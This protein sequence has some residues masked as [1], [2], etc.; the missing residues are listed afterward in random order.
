MRVRAAVI[1]A[2]LAFALVFAFARPGVHAQNHDG[3]VSPELPEQVEWWIDSDLLEVPLVRPPR[4]ATRV[5]LR[6]ATSEER[7][8][9]ASAGKWGPND[10]DGLLLLDLNRDG[11]EDAF[12]CVGTNGFSGYCFVGS[13]HDEG[14]E[15][16]KTDVDYPLGLSGAHTAA[17]DLGTGRYLMVAGLAQ[18]SPGKHKNLVQIVRYDGTTFVTETAYEDR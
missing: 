9:L 11:S 4:G 13:R 5:E 16:T 15:F 14:W 2:T 18:P 3:V 7:R 1:A 12:G 8:A 6:P 17:F 10:L